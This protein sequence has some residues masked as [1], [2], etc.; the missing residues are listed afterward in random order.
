MDKRCFLV[1]EDGSV[2]RGLSFGAEP[3]EVASIAE[4]SSPGKGAG[5]VVFNTSMTGYQ[6]ILSDPSYTG[7]LVVMTY[8]HAGNYG[9]SDDWSEAGVSGFDK[10]TTI[11]ASGFVVRRYSGGAEPEGR[12]SLDKVLKDSGI[13]GVQDVDTRAL[14]LRIRD[15][16]SPKGIVVR[17]SGGDSLSKNEVDSVVAY[18]TEFPNMEGRNLVAD[19]GVKKPVDYGSEKLSPHIALIDCGLKTNILREL[20]ARFCRV[21]LFPNNV[22]S[23]TILSSKPDAVL[24]SNGPGDPAVLTELIETIKELIGKIPVFGICLGHQLISLALGATT[25][26]MKFGHHG[27]NHPVR[28]ENTKKVFVTSQNHGFS[29]L[30]TSVPNHVRIWFRNANDGT[31]EGLRHETLPV[32]CVQFHPEAAP[33]PRDSLWIFDEFLREASNCPRGK[34]LIK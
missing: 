18:L 11:H 31:V 8:P 10:K 33:G 13:P 19:L 6:E 22:Q 30:E 14:T 21:T 26:K 28:D 20:T 15:G 34:I 4:L 23:E 29:V 12:Y 7:Q 1:L 3:T 32:M 5:E 24:L 25:Y 16:G 17:A 2:F 9:V 27:A